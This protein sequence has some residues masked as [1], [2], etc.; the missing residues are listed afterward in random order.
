VPFAAKR[1]IDLRRLGRWVFGP[2]RENGFPNATNQRDVSHGRAKYINGFIE[3]GRRRPAV[4]GQEVARALSA[5]DSRDGT[6]VYERKLEL[7]GT[8]YPSLCLAGGKLF[9][10]SDSGTTVVIEPG[11]EYR[12]LARN[13]LGEGFRSTPCFDDK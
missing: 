7:G 13:S 5:I 10:S 11:R 8:A 3:T 6:I 12:Q 2:R 1:G 9:A 4:H